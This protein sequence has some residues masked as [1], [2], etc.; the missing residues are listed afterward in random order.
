MYL[1]LPHIYLS[2]GLSHIY[3]VSIHE[4]LH[5]YPAPACIESSLPFPCD[6][7]MHILSDPGLV[8]F[9]WSLDTRC[10]STTVFGTFT[11]FSRLPS[12]III[13]I[14]QTSSKIVGRG[15]SVSFV[16][17][18]SAASVRCGLC[19]HFFYPST[20][21]LAQPVSLPIIY[22]REIHG[23]SLPLLNHDA[24]VLLLYSTYHPL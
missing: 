21:N 8:M 15:D 13:G 10:S 17:F 23:L 2:L 12:T 3:I 19:S 20:P 9:S 7:H 11:N 22:P 5:R 18:Q 4:F 14:H 24:H 1:R 6:T 16:R